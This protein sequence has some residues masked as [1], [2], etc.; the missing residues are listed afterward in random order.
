MA[1][2]PLGCQR[3]VVRLDRPQDLRVLRVIVR[4]V[5]VQPQDLHLL[6]LRTDPAACRSPVPSTAL[7]PQRATP[8]WKPRL[9]ALS[10]GS[11]VPASSSAASSMSLASSAIAASSAS[12]G[13]AGEV[14][15]DQQ[16]RVEQVEQRLDL[17][18]PRIR[19]REHDAA[20]RRGAHRRRIRAASPRRRPPAAAAAPP[21]SSAPPP[22]SG[23]RAPARS[24][25][26]RP[27]AARRARSGRASARSACPSRSGARRRPRSPESSNHL[28]D[29]VVKSSCSL[30]VQA[31]VD[32][33]RP[34]PPRLR[35]QGARRAGR[36]RAAATSRPGAAAARRDGA[37][38]AAPS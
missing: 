21:A 8:R 5:R 6:G 15:L 36:A 16:P 18:R 25:A 24:A 11:S 27:N 2:H 34:I 4:A 12:R 30:S 29:L 32:P 33:A 9:A 26:G 1:L 37:A 31:G 14:G 19:V 20:A 7:P 22:R 23:W 3:R 28:D 13:E 17:Q 35:R 38:C 10:G